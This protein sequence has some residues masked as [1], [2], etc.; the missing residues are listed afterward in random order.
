MKINEIIKKLKKE[1]ELIETDVDNQFF[2][3][4]SINSNDIKPNTFFICKGLSFKEKY[5]K[6]AIAKGVNIYVSEVKYDVDIPFVIVKDIRKTLAI[7][8]KMFYP[9]TLIKIGMTGTKGKT[10]TINFIKNIL[11]EY[12]TGKVGWITTSGVYTK[13]TDGKTHNTTPESID[14]HKFLNEM[15]NNDFK[16]SVVE[17][18]SQATKMFRTYGINFEIG[19]LTNIGLDHISTHEHKDFNEYFD[20]KMEFLKNCNVVV[21]NKEDEHFLKT[22][23]ILSNK[24]IITY[25]YNDADYLIKDIKSIDSKLKEF[26]ICHEEDEKKYRIPLIGD[27]NI[28]NATCAIA[29]AEYFNI[30]YESILKGLEETK[31]PGRLEVYENFLCPVIVD[32][33]HNG[34]AVKAVIDA[35]KKEYPG[36]KIK[37]LVG[38]SGDKAQNRIVQVGTIA[39][40]YA[41]YTY[42]TTKNPQHRDPMDISKEIASYIEKNNGKY[43]IV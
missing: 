40:L 6:E 43:E 16:Y 18:S 22:K 3:Y 26:T 31:V 32:T 19:G 33:A 20:C 11:N 27:F 2:D 41:D 13:T 1:N 38:C 8:S 39:G 10:T 36:K 34:T 15:G 4:I 7:I 25:G 42:I 24:K 37:L 5:L 23:E 14:L 29:I 17:V 30:D 35:I 21:L 28:L 12:E 9:D